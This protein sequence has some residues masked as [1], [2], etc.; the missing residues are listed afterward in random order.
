MLFSALVNDIRD[1]RAKRD[2]LLL[3]RPFWRKV[4][5][6]TKLPPPV[7]PRA[8]TALVLE[9]PLVRGALDTRRFNDLS[10]YRFTPPA[11]RASMI[12]SVITQLV[13]DMFNRTDGG[14]EMMAVLSTQHCIRML[15][16][17]GMRV[18]N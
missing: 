18:R 2:D 3:K 1:A 14:K 12:S 4:L 13:F 8:A 5:F 6:W 9:Q 10:M 11:L 15:H 16:E 7:P 17:D